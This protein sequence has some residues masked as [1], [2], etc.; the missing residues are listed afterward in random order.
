[1]TDFI[2]LSALYLEGGKFCTL[3]N[4]SVFNHIFLGSEKVYKCDMVMLAMGFLGPENVIIDD[5]K[6][7]QDPRSN[8]QT[9]QGKYATSLPRVY[10]AGGLYIFI[11]K[12][13][14]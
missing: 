11:F 1:M 6:L 3:Y 2:Q 12:T 14:G 4:F 8:I 7:E 10:A 13:R 9:P 5:L